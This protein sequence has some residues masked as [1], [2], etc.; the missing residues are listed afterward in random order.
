MRIRVCETRFHTWSK[1]HVVTV[2]SA[3][4]AHCFQK[5]TIHHPFA[6]VSFGNVECHGIL[7]WIRIEEPQSNRRV[8]KRRRA[9]GCWQLLEIGREERS[10]LATKEKVKRFVGDD[11]D[12]CPLRPDVDQRGYVLEFVQVCDSIVSNHLKRLSK[13]KCD[14]SWCW[15]LEFVSYLM[16]RSMVQSINSDWRTLWN[17]L[18]FYSCR[19]VSTVKPVLSDHP[20]VQGK[21]VVIDR[22]SL[23]QGFPR[24]RPIFRSSVEQL[25]TLWYA[26]VW[27]TQ[28]QFTS[29]WCKRWPHAIVYS[30]TCAMVAVLTVN[31]GTKQRFSLLLVAKDRENPVVGAK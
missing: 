26:R 12:E 27:S 24:N 7:V 30:Q 11:S 19:K 3:D 15:A 16:L 25:R 6:D 29:I 28:W 10:R 13:K 14:C 23:K 22:W 20:T 1:V 18:L 5:A 31:M 4:G 21:V 9:F 8:F 17:E 2:I